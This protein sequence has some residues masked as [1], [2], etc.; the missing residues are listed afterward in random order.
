MRTLLIENICK[1]DTAIDRNATATLQ[2]NHVEM[3]KL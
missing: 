1:F 3:Q 2:D